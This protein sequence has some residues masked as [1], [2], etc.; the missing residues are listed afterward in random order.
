MGIFC[1]VRP[2]IERRTVYFK[3]AVYY[4]IY[5][6][7]LFGSIL[8]RLFYFLISYIWIDTIWLKP[9]LQRRNSLG[10]NYTGRVTS[11]VIFGKSVCPSCQKQRERLEHICTSEIYRGITLLSASTVDSTVY[12]VAPRHS[13]PRKTR[14][15]QGSAAGF[16][17]G[18]THESGWL[19]ENICTVCR[20]TLRENKTCKQS[21]NMCMFVSVCVTS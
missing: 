5:C 17:R 16:A 2:H 20:C 14:K 6:N 21:K 3:I 7:S 18:W 13:L 15:Q 12:R 9:C 8:L 1:D 19:P 4:C 11:L 10:L